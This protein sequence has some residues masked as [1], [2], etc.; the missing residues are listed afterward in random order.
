MFP[1]PHCFSPKPISSSLFLS[2]NRGLFPPFHSS[3]P[4][5]SPVLAIRLLTGETSTAPSPVN[6]RC[7]W[8]SQSTLAVPACPD[9]NP[10]G[11]PHIPPAVTLTLWGRRRRPQPSGWGHHCAAV[12][13]PQAGF[14]FFFFFYLPLLTSS[15]HHSY[16]SSIKNNWY[17]APE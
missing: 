10:V 12:S 11:P 9:P 8:V 6:L 3:I 14:F 4:S 16:F 7:T 2:F 17:I 13:H 15:L 5:P 1:P